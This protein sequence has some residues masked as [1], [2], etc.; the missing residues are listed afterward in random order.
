MKNTLKKLGAIALVLML[1]MS[2]S[3]NAFAET[4][5]PTSDAA[6]A[7]TQPDKPVAQDKVLR[8]YKDITAYNQD[9][10]DVAAPTITFQYAIA[11]GNAGKNVTDAKSDH[12]SNTA[13]TAPTIAGV[14]AGLTMSSQTNT[15]A[16]ATT[17]LAWTTE[18]TLKT[19]ANGT[20]GTVGN[21]ANSKYVDIDFTNVVFGA[22]G[23]YR[24]VITESLPTED[25]YAAS[26]V[27]DGSSHTR[28]LDVYVKPAD[29]GFNNGSTAAEWVIYGYAMFTGDDDITTSTTKTPGFV[30]N[31]KYYT[32]NVTVSK[33]IENDAAM[34]AVAHQ[35]P[36]TVKFTNATV[37]KNVLIKETVTAPATSGTPTAGTLSHEINAS[38]GNDL[39]IGENT[40]QKGSVKY[41]GIPVGTAVEVKEKND[42]T[43]TTYSVVSKVDS[44]AGTAAPLASG[45]T[46]S[47][48][49]LAAPTADQAD[50]TSHTIEFVNTLV[51]ISPTGVVMRVAPYAL[52]LIGGLVLLVISRRRKAEE[53]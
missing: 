51:L 36:F 16:A 42:V 4:T 38:L 52:M 46:S 32:Y 25:T 12:A 49:Q 28:Y 27:T 24:Y 19:A 48:A 50:T 7:Y 13:V 14:T 37:T 18:D 30:G 41:I 17:T 22:T 29:S 47:A 26:G 43:G 5:L 6:G 2:L 20:V 15:T 45:A 3:V 40:T 9:A 31:D 33:D 35:F 1:M 10:A 8:F 53:A 21:D 39:K 23:V 11:A 44:T 34:V